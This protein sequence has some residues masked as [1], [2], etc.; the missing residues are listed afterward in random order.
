MRS[1]SGSEHQV[2]AV[3]EGEQLPRPDTRS[4]TDTYDIVTTLTTID[5]TK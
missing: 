5:V 2:T 3:R 4:D 1:I